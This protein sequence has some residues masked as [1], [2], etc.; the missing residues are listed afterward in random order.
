MLPP[1][2]SPTSFWNH[3]LRH[4]LPLHRH[5]RCPPLPP[6]RQHAFGTLGSP[7]TT[8]SC[9]HSALVLWRTY[10]LN[11]SACVIAQ[12]GEFLRD[13]LPVNHFHSVLFLPDCCVI[14]WFCLAVTLKFDFLKK[15]TTTLYRPQPLLTIFYSYLNLSYH[16]ISAL[17]YN[18]IT[19]ISFIRT[20]YTSLL[21]CYYMLYTIDPIHIQC[22]VLTLQM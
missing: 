2:R 8:A 13:V 14:A 19:I 15:N 17:M 4:P 10:S 5:V 11:V 16:Y 6:P 18:S 21:N 20:H 3:I 12:Q 7:P 22:Y 9:A 1:H